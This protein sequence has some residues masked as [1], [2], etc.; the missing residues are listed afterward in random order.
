VTTLSGFLITDAELKNLATRLKRRCGTG[1]SVKDGVIII[2][3]D[4]RNILVVELKNQGFKV[5]IAGG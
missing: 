5:K 1:G 3:G 2:Q 4:H